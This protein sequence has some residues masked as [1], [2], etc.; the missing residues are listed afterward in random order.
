[1]PNK[2]PTRSSE[3]TGSPRNAREEEIAR[4]SP[5]VIVSSRNKNVERGWRGISQETGSYLKMEG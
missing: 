3:E 4:S 1:M 2:N 5:N